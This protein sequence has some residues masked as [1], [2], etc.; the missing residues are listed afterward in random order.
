MTREPAAGDCLVHILVP[1]YGRVEYLREAVQS[2]VAELGRHGDSRSVR[3]TVVDDASPTSDIAET[4]EAFP[5]VTYVRN[6]QNLGMVGNFN[7]CLEIS[8]GTYTV[9]MG[10]DD[11]FSPGYLEQVV[12]A[13]REFRSP[14]IICPS[15]AVIDSLSQPS[16]PLA[17]RVKRVIMP[18]RTGRVHSRASG[19]FICVESS[20]D[21]AV[22]RLMMGDYL[23]FPA[24]AWETRALR[25]VGFSESAGVATDLYAICQ[26][27]LRNGTLVTFR[28]R[29]AAFRYRRHAESA[30]SVG[31]E[32]GTR[33]EEER[34]VHEQVGRLAR[35]RGWKLTP[36]AASLRPTSRLHAWSIRVESSR[37]GHALTSISS[38]GE[39]KASGGQPPDRS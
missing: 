16:D 19:T 1:S 26:C 8:E 21:R 3:V 4:V 34:W 18:R 29:R 22:A 15:V 38:S 28:S 9:F 32:D 10:S 36:L 30:S 5:E 6:D 7:R 17:D 24:L 33:V 12:F 11:V 2:V 14:T 27:L 37:L 25:S 31:A 39:G 20:G 23:Y 13:I 35:Q